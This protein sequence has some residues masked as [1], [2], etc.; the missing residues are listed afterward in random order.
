MK[1]I[2]F[3]CRAF[4]RLTTPDLEN[5]IRSARNTAGAIHDATGGKLNHFYDSSGTKIRGYH[6]R[7]KFSAPPLHPLAIKYAEIR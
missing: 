4:H 2:S 6:K 1:A 7:I 5:K 3:L